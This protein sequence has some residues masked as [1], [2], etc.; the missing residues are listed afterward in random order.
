MGKEGKGTMGGG[1]KIA[2]GARRAR[3]GLIVQMHCAAV[4]RCGYLKGK[5]CDAGGAGRGKVED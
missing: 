4:P 2:R 5:G 3:L 1:R